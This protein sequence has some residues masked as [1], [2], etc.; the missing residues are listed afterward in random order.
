MSPVLKISAGFFL[1]LLGMGYLFRPDIIERINS[2]IKETL[3][4]DSYVA[5]ERKK[6]G[7]FFIL[8]GFLLFY[9]GINALGISG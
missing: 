5:L 2:L 7:T 9:M 6:W 4:N 1:C 3:L 8:L